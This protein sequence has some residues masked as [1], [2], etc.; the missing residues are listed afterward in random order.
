MILAPEISIVLSK[1]GM[2]AAD[3]RCKTFD[4]AAD[5]FVRGEGCGI[6]CSSGFRTPSAAGD[7]ILAV[8]RGTAVNQ[9]GRS[10]GLTAPNGP[11]QQALLRE[12]LADA[13][14]HPTRYS[15]SRRMA[16]APS[17]G[18]PIEVQALAAVLGE[19]RTTE[20]PLLIGSVKTNIGHL[21]CAAGVAGFIKA[22]LAM[23]HRE[24]PP[25]LHLKTLNPHI[26]WAELPISVP[27]RATPWPGGPGPRIAGVSSFGFSGTN[28]HVL[29]EGSAEEPARPDGPDRPIHLLCLSAKSEQAPRSNWRGD[30][31]QHLTSRSLGVAGRRVLYGEHRPIPFCPPPDGRGRQPRTTC[32]PARSIHRRE[33]RAGYRSGTRR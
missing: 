22:V 11:A 31:E 27:T 9:D 17:L 15:T 12:A 1:A 32:S 20:N 18:D 3:G 5:G 19:G 28:A 8:I 21:E 26:N 4:A 13:G 25:H 6:V 33:P 16:R 24:I 2:M 14:L 23:R 10:A 29:L 7:R 30:Y